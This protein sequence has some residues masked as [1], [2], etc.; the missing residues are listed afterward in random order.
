M[1]RFILHSIAFGIM[2]V[3]L[4]VGA[5]EIGRRLRYQGS[6][7]LDKDAQFAW[8]TVRDIPALFA[9]KTPPVA[10]MKTIR[11]ETT[12]PTSEA[13]LGLSAPPAL[14]GDGRS[15]PA[16]REMAAPVVVPLPQAT[17]RPAATTDDRI[18]Y[19]ADEQREFG[20]LLGIMAST[21]GELGAIRR[22]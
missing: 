12:A 16:S 13:P 7:G 4:F 21:R 20:R 18:P 3:V 8:R 6:I 10:P 22:E 15:S 11:P 17:D 14:A 2:A 19:F 5:N 9:G 1:F